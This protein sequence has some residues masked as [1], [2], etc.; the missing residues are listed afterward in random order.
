MSDQPDGIT[1]V[2]QAYSD[3]VEARDVE[4]FLA[5]YDDGMHL[6]DM[7]DHY[8]VNGKDAWRE[9][10]AGWFGA[11]PGE[12]LEARFEDVSAVSGQDVAFA[13]MVM[14]FAIVAPGGELSYEQAHRM[15]L[16]IQ[17]KDGAWKIVHEHTS[18]P[19]NNETGAGI[20]DAR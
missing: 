1:Q 9:M 20:L 12:A 3:A 10:V 18:M 5:L 11:H 14:T 19:I 13:H 15:T 16:G 2:L 6:F 17:R 8:E 7:W 4:T